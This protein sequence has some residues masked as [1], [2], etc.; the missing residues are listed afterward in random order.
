MDAKS[1]TT[2]IRRNSSRDSTRVKSTFFKSWRKYNPSKSPAAKKIVVMEE[3]GQ[4]PELVNKLGKMTFTTQVEA[5][6]TAYS[7]V[8][9]LLT[10][11]NGKGAEE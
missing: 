4:E 6:Y 7:K 2:S 5:F 8:S 1:R 9:H 11:S 3:A 10:I